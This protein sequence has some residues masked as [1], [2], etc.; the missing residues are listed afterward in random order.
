MQKVSNTGNV[1]IKYCR[2]GYF[3]CKQT[4]LVSTA[5]LALPN[6]GQI[7]DPGLI[8]EGIAA[9]SAMGTLVGEGVS[10]ALSNPYVAV[11]IV[12]AGIVLFA[13][14]QTKDNVTEVVDV[15]E[16]SIAKKTKDLEDDRFYYAGLVRNG[17]ANSVIIVYNYSMDVDGAV[18]YIEAVTMNQSV[19]N[20]KT[21]D[22]V[23]ITLNS[24]YTFYDKQALMLCEKLTKLPL[25][26]YEYGDDSK[27]NHKIGCDKQFK[28]AGILYYR[29]Y[30]IYM[31]RISSIGEYKKV[32][33]LHI[34]F[35][36]PY[37]IANPAT[38][39]TC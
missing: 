14:L 38:R 3:E 16:I 32:L 7:L 29:H 35:G 22:G 37:T 39:Y 21:T 27:P 17:A 26:L 9:L 23:E 10:A 4:G 33:G 5:S 34:F 11:V 1:N 13:C 31:R 8:G 20:V 36:N 18:R 15:L 12:V 24:L 6:G 28:Q 2:C 25:D 30:H 19:K